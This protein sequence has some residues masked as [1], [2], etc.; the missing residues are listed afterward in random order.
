MQIRKLL[1]YFN[2]TFLVLLL[3]FQFLE[4]H[5]VSKTNYS[6]GHKLFIIKLAEF[7]EN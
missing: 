2:V 3:N 1:Q 4:F 6:L 7:K 5:I